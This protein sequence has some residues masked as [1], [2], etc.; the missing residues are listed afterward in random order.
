[1]KT[2]NVV[3]AI[4]VAFTLL[5]LFMSAAPANSSNE[6]AK[7][8]VA[9][10]DVPLAIELPFL[11][12]QIVT[13]VTTMPLT[14]SV[15]KDGVQDIAPKAAS[16]SPD[17]DEEKFEAYSNI[18][19]SATLQKKINAFA[20]KKDIPV[21][22]VFAMMEQESGFDPD[23]VSGT[24]D[25]GI[26]QINRSNFKWL[27]KDLKQQYGID[28]KW[29]DSYSSAVAGIHYLAR[30]KDSWKNSGVSD[31]DMLSVVLLSYNMGTRNASKYMK[32]HD[33]KDWDYVQH[34]IEYKEKIESGEEL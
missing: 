12:S 4:V 13:N 6:V 11:Y 24:H 15:Q 21:T 33:P 1:M 28:F 20:E 23:E 8:P 19:L 10:A 16:A 3:I 32:H 7:V 14:S 17:E 30:I 34:I 26:M 22:L 2:K 9:S 5:I 18:P 27:T 29:N 25:Y 31:E